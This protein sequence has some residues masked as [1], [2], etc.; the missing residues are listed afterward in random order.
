[1]HSP[2][3]GGNRSRSPMWGMGNVT[4][5]ERQWAVAGVPWVVKGPPMLAAGIIGGTSGLVGK[6]A[7]RLF[8]LATRPLFWAGVNVYQEAQ[9]IRSWMRGDDMSWQLSVKWRPIGPVGHGTGRFMQ[10]GIP[11]FIPVP[12]PYLDFTRTLSSGGGGPGEIP[13]LHRPPSIEESG[14]LI[15]NPPMVG[16]VVSIPSSSTSRKSGKRRKPCPPGYRWNGRRCVRKG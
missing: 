16:D 7:I 15:T 5:V 9:D 2:G 13:N 10:P 6:S 1:M 8:N 4:A 14:K 11:L 12:F 3:G